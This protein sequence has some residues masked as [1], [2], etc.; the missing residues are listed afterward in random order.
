MKCYLS[1]LAFKTC[2]AHRLWIGFV[3]W[4][5]FQISLSFNNFV[6]S[7]P[8]ACF[9]GMVLRWSLQDLGDSWGCKTV[10]VFVC[11]QHV[12]QH[13]MQQCSV[14]DLLALLSNSCAICVIPAWAE[15]LPFYAQDVKKN[16]EARVRSWN[17]HVLCTQWLLM[18]WSKHYLQHKTTSP[19]YLIPLV[20]FNWS[21][22]KL[23]L[24]A[25]S[26]THRHGLLCPL[27]LKQKHDFGS[28]QLNDLIIEL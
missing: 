6:Y 15:F 3:N 27:V 8:L 19:W 14:E 16:L 5:R 24:F 28:P 2:V 4:L 26:A 9:V 7:P 18:F 12:R 20:T 23:C 17:S 25:C 22:R 13:L 11:G 10:S 1:N 21:N